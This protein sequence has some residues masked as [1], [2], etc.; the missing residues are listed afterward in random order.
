MKRIIIVGTVLVLVIGLWSAAWLYGATLIRQQVEAL[1][2]ADGQ[3]TPRLVCDRF[4][5]GGWPFYFDVTCGDMTV[6]SGDLTFSVAEVRASAE[7]Y[8]PWLV[9]ASLYGPMQVA[10]AFTGSRQQLDWKRIEASLRLKDWRIAR[11]SVVGEELALADTVAEPLPLA[12]AKQMEF[13]LV[14]VPAAHD[15][16]KHTAALKLHALVADLNAEQ[17]GIAAGQSTLDG[18]LAGLPDDVRDWGAPDMLAR[19]AANAGALTLDSFKGSDGDAGS[20][21]IGGHLGLDAEIRPAGQFTITSKGLVERFGT[22]V[23]EQWRGLVLG[24]PAADGSYKQSITLANGVIIAGLLPV[25][26]VPSLK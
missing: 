7:A 5:V 6:T 26:V 15:A 22:L 13:H 9:V 10:D 18:T 11:L 23:P 8:D 12:K 2:S 25:G 14:D 16:Q 24:N 4:G 21:D 17:F 1:A 20:F 3:A 19:F